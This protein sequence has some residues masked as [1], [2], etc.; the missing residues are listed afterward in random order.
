M[1]FFLPDWDDRVDPLYNFEKDEP[2]PNRDPYEHDAY[3]YELYGTLNCDGILVSKS[4]LEKNA[5]KREKAC[6]KGIH[7]YLRLPRNV[8]VFGD[9]G[10]FSYI[11]EENPPYETEEILEY[12][13]RLGFDFGVSVDHLIVPGILRRK[14]FFKKEND[15]WN[16]IG[17]DEF[18]R[19][20]ESPNTVVARSRGNHRQLDLFS[21]ADVIVS[22]NHIDETERER[23]YE[24]TIENAFRFLERHREGGHKF[25][26][27][28]A[29]QGWDAESYSDAVKDYQRMGYK[30][31]ALGG[32]VRSTTN[33]ILRVLESVDRVRTPKTKI[34]LFGVARLDAIESFMKLG[35]TSVDS[36]GVLRQAWL[37]SSSNYYSPDM[38]HYT[39]IRIPPARTDGDGDEKMIRDLETQCLSSLRGFD[40]EVVPLEAAL[41]H[42]MAYNEVMGGDQRLRDHYIRTL[43]EKP[44]KR[45]PCDICGKTGVDIIIFRRNNRNRRRGFHNTWVF[46]NKFRELTDIS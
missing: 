28:G 20:R 43:S 1:L 18:L 25:T 37:S 7:R 14:R 34:H 19:R 40:N 22:E 3:H 35:V 16:E 10:A 21:S 27:V 4:V 8:P 24:L 30:Y 41:E 12:Y 44:W 38:K 17:E 11:A 23:R 31:I 33:E 2:T 29:I 5:L 42:I 36:A 9:C 26:P 6:R 39:A 32:L 45:C 13:S 46:F 15:G